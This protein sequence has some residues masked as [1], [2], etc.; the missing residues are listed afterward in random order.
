MPGPGPETPSAQKPTE[1]QET[2]PI[3]VALL[4]PSQSTPFARAAEAVRLGFFA[5]HSVANANLAIQLLEIDDNVAELRTALATAQ[6]HGVRIV[7]GPLTRTLVNALGDGRVVAPLP[8]LTLNLPESDVAVSPQS[9]AFGLAVEAESRQVVRLALQDLPP[10]AS[11]P[12]NPRFLILAGESPLA[13]RMATAFRDA[14]RDHG[15]RSTQIDVHVRYEFL[16]T[17]TEQLAALKIDAVFCALDARETAF[18]RPRLPR[19]LPLYATSQVNL[20]GAE[21]ALLAPDLDGVKFVDM[22]WLIE[23]EHAAVMV[24]P[25]SDVALSGELQRLYALGIDAYRVMIEWLAGRREFD[26]DGVTGRLHVDRDKS[27][28]V[29]RWPTLAVFRSGKIETLEQIQ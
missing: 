13:R 12:A 21:S 28:R 10:P 23:P 6:K 18:V 27:P 25:R 4:L 15:E 5:A 19:E 29:E 26:L 3:P 9:L 17:L 24:Y 11:T 1:K 7:V 8:V 16:Q 22:P 2:A 14:L 20:G